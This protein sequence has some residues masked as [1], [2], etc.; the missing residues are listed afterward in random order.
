MLNGRIIK[1]I[2]MF[3]VSLFVI[4]L[5]LI[6]SSC[7]NFN[8]RHSDEINNDY[9]ESIN[10]A[11]DYFSDSMLNHFPNHISDSNFICL[12]LPYYEKSNRYGI[13]VLTKSSPTEICDLMLHLTYDKKVMFSDKNVLITD[14]INIWDESIPSDSLVIIPN[15]PRIFKRNLNQSR[16]SELRMNYFVFFIIKSSSQSVLEGNFLSDGIGLPNE[17]KNGYSKG[18]A[19][20]KNDNE[21]IFWF[22]AW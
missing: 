20:N 9:I 1:L 22:E 8:E 14:S 19:I 3:R 12:K 2:T 16:I 10:L 21:L 6:I 15:F 18:I 11:N 13:T 17:W 7:K 4:S 5:F